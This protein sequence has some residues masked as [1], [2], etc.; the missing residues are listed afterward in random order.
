MDELSWQ[1]VAHK[2]HFPVRLDLDH[3][4]SLGIWAF[5]RTTNLGCFAPC[6]SNLAYSDV[7]I[8]FVVE[9]V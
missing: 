8:N 2:L 4:W 6:H 1:N 3:F 9:T 5:S 7:F